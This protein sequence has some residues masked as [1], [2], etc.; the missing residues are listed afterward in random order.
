MPYCAKCLMEYV[1]GTTQCEDCGAP[2]LTGSLPEAPPRLEIPHEK[3]VKLV[4]ARIFT[5]G[6]ARM[7]AELARNIL[8]T[9]GIA[10]TMAGEGLSDPLPVSEVHLLVREEDVGRAGEVLRDYLDVEVPPTP[11]EAGSA[12]GE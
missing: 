1:D 9:Q 11:E 7:D 5:G 10:S 3:N 8:Q 12:E 4:P 6:S 2:L